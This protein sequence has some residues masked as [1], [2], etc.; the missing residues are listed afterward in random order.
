M[1][2]RSLAQTLRQTAAAIEASRQLLNRI[3]AGDHRTTHLVERSWRALE[4]ARTQLQIHS[5]RAA[6]ERMAH[7]RRSQDE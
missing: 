1:R 6:S 7:A 5:S 4:E 2:D 3:R